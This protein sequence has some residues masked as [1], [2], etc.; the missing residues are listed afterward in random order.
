MKRK[1]FTSQRSAIRNTWHSLLLLGTFCL[2][3]VSS[4]LFAQIK[5]SDNHFILHSVT[6]PDLTGLLAK[7]GD[8]GGIRLG[9]TKP[10]LVESAEVISLRRHGTT[11]PPFPL[12]NFVVLTNGDWITLS[13]PR[14]DEER[15]RFV[16][17]G[18]RPEQGEETAVPLAYVSQ[19]WLKLPEGQRDV[20]SL[21]RR[22][23]GQPPTA[24]VVFLINGDRIEGKVAGLDP[25]GC[26]VR[27]G[28][29]DILLSLE[30]L[31]G[32]VFSGELQAPLRSRGPWWHVVL[33]DGSRLGFS[34]LRL[35]AGRPVFSGKA[36]AGPRLEIPLPGVVA[37][38]RRQGRA[39]YLSDLKA[40]AYQH[41][42]FFGVHWPLMADAS[43]NGQPLRLAGQTYDKGLGLHSHSRVS[44]DLAGQYQRLEATVGLDDLAGHR[45]RA[46]F[47][48]LVDGKETDW[49]GP[50][51]LT[52]GAEPLPVRVNVQGARELT[53]VVDFGRFGPVGGQVN[54]ANARLIRK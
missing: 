16:P 44:Y 50:G 18:L 27:T 19:L 3:M 23:T 31:A 5:E 38:D 51:E 41:T 52:A 48:V 43:V 12:G 47:Q 39:V 6:G 33:V 13:R 37:L 22:F 26:R 17:S 14:L 20:F 40:K 2:L 28:S 36:L 25:K 15:L 7:I 46:R 35:D 21:V 1:A 11:L 49:G 34:T 32:I 24:D 42:P 45:G 4:P 29:Q 9:G 54:L 30:R 53:L 10:A 8:D